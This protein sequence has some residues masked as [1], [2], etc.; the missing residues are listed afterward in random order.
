MFNPILIYCYDAYCGWCYGFSDIIKKI[1]EDYSKY[2]QIEVLSGGMILPNKP[3]HI[4]AIADYKK[5]EYLTVEASTRAK[6]GEDYLWHINQPNL[7]DWFPNSEKPSIALCIFKEYH[8]EKQVEIAT[9]LQRS[10]FLEGRDLT[11]DE[12][13]RHLLDLYKIEHHEFYEKLHDK[14]Y[15]EK[16]NY[17]FQLCKQLNVS[18]YPTVLLQT[19]ESKFY[20]VCNGYS[21]FETVNKQLLNIL[22]ESLSRS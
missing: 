18:G 11:D 6:F 4:S 16:A 20:L 2:L 14:N 12:S 17:E 21:D 3:V 22:K 7:S 10:L 13:Y 15:R 8:P 9:A 19:E 5:S 1:D